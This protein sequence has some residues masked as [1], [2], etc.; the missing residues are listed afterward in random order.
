MDKQS[1]VVGAAFA[2]GVVVAVVQVVVAWH[3]I[4]KYW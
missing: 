3:F 1:I 2:I 4:V